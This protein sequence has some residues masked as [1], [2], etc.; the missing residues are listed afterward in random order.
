VGWMGRVVGSLE[1]C[2]CR[3]ARC[4]GRLLKNVDSRVLRRSF[5]LARPPFLWEAIFCGEWLGGCTQRSASE[6][7]RTRLDGWGGL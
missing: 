5:E 4:A 3:S 6:G 7:E 2:P 1:E